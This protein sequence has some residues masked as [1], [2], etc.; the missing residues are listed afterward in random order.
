MEKQGITSLSGGIGQVTIGKDRRQENAQAAVDADLRGAQA[1]LKEAKVRLAMGLGASFGG[2]A[3]TLPPVESQELYDEIARAAGGLE[4]L[5]ANE[6]DAFRFLSKDVGKEIAA[7]PDGINRL[8]R[9]LPLFQNAVDLVFELSDRIASN[10]RPDPELLLSAMRPYLEESTYLFPAF[11]EAIR[12]C[13]GVEGHPGRIAEL[14][15]EVVGTLVSE[16]NLDEA[17]Q[18]ISAV[19]MEDEFRSS[20]GFAQQLIV[21]FGGD[22]VRLLGIVESF[23]EL[24][25]LMRSN[26]RVKQA[27]VSRIVEGSGTLVGFDT[28]Q[29]IADF[30]LTWDLVVRDQAVF[31][32]FSMPSNLNKMQTKVRSLVDRFKPPR[33]AV[34]RM[35]DRSATSIVDD[36]DSPIDAAAC[37]ALRETFGLSDQEAALISLEAVGIRR[38]RESLEHDQNAIPLARRVLA[39]SS[40]PETFLA[41]LRSPEM[42]SIASDA[43]HRAMMLDEF[44][45]ARELEFFG[46][47]PEKM[48]EA[49][50]DRFVV[51]LK[52][53]VSGSVSDELCRV[54]E[55]PQ[56]ALPS[57]LVVPA[58]REGIETCISGKLLS[59]LV[60]FVF[61]QRVT[62]EM[63]SATE[64]DRRRVESLVKD[65]IATFL[66]MNDEERSALFGLYGVSE[67]VLRSPD[68][69]RRVEEQAVRMIERSFSCLRTLREIVPEISDQAWYRDACKKKVHK[70]IKDGQ[71]RYNDVGL[72]MA[73]FC[74][75][76]A[77]PA[78]SFRTPEIVA[79]A[80]VCVAQLLNDERYESIPPLMELFG[81]SPANAMKLDLF[82]GSTKSLYALG[83]L[84]DRKTADAWKSEGV[85]ETIAN[86]QRNGPPNAKRLTKYYTSRR[87]FEGLAMAI[88]LG[89]ATVPYLNESDAIR[90]LQSMVVKGD[91]LAAEGMLKCYGLTGV[92][93]DAALRKRIKDA[94][95]AERQRRELRVE[96]ALDTEPH[97]VEEEMAGFYV[98]EWI[99]FELSALERRVAEEHVDLGFG[100]KMEAYNRREAIRLSAE[101]QFDWLREYLVRSVLGEMRHQSDANDLPRSSYVKIPPIADAW[102]S[103]ATNEEIRQTMAASADR[104]REPG[105]LSSYG[106]EPWARIADT[107]EMMFATNP[108]RRK[109]IDLTYDLEH[110]GG[111]VFNK[112]LQRVTFNSAGHLKRILDMKR[113]VSDPEALLALLERELSP[114]AYRTVTDRWNEWK[115]L[116]SRIEARIGGKH[117]DRH[118]RRL[119]DIQALVAF[120]V[121]EPKIFS[122][123]SQ[124]EPDALRKFLTSEAVVAGRAG[125]VALM[126]AAGVII[127]KRMYASGDGI[128]GVLREL[129]RPGW[130]GRAEADS[131]APIVGAYLRARADVASDAAEMNVAQ[132]V[133]SF[134]PNGRAV[135]SLTIVN[136]EDIPEDFQRLITELTRG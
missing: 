11:L 23:P 12:R 49:A 18:L 78:E 93:F 87:N 125:R 60:E 47:D 90:E 2:M 110:N 65:D 50:I 30:G 31:H 63:A 88:D 109:L 59:T 91:G 52:N 74:A 100:T 117:E 10:E 83:G 96:F 135:D 80:R 64:Q 8:L 71:A 61:S 108:D 102:M 53:G 130:I 134:R 132:D 41:S 22:P 20:R 105:W 84:I 13:E 1:K 36:G 4:W 14:A 73:N 58:I 54:F 62:P 99:G 75:L 7:G 21:N 46:V 25:S 111:S 127:R 35:A 81:V 40:R 69:A 70:F 51:L 118:A 34:L 122:R 43:F 86:L 126:H 116:R 27:L 72:F 128:A 67:Q 19:R 121:D 57:A 114:E 136:A 131:F 55:I 120:E 94:A 112:E 33:D 92:L 79:A 5:A 28:D 97:R 66:V 29:V 95:D 119:A 68:V 101:N 44:V 103:M 16:G 56:K 6:P 37:L 104:F 26:G 98:D 133:L 38:V 39:A 124:M 123:M 82:A 48:R 106:G 17:L 85:P 89:A 115:G 24:E 113:E 42:R 3:A 129:R 45:A 9:H 107:A 15:G 77:I 76:V 32:W